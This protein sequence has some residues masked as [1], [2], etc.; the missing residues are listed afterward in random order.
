VSVRVV[1]R[2]QFWENLPPASSEALLKWQEKIKAGWRP[3]RRIRQMVMSSSSSGSSLGD[4]KNLSGILAL[5]NE[6]G[7]S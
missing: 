7:Y 2:Y 6:R 3:N 4:L 5:P 1:D